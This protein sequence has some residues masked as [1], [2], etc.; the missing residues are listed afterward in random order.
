MILFVSKRLSEHENF[1]KLIDLFI[2]TTRKTFYTIDNDF[3]YKKLSLNILAYLGLMKEHAGFVGY[4]SFLG[5]FNH[6]K[7]DYNIKFNNKEYTIP[8]LIEE[9]KVSLENIIP[10]EL[11]F[12]KNLSLITKSSD[13]N[14]LII[15]EN[16]KETQQLLSK[17]N[18]KTVLRLDLSDTNKDTESF[19]SLLKLQQTTSII[20]INVN[21]TEKKLAEVVVMLCSLINTESKNSV[22]VDCSIELKDKKETAVTKKAD[23][24]AVEAVNAQV[25]QV[26]EIQMDEDDLDEDEII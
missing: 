21:F 13:S 17:L 8:T 22:K 24:M 4:G 3:I 16:E 19:E 20:P 26:N 1:T 12:L 9:L 15:E 5:L 2:L 25:I 7:D 23:Q 11:I 18:P 10:F 14:V 6:I